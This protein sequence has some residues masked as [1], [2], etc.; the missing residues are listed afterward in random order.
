MSNQRVQAIL[1]EWV[2]SKMLIEAQINSEIADQTRTALKGLHQAS[3]AHSDIRAAN[4]LVRDNK[5]YL[6]DLNA[7][8]TLPHVRIS[9]QKL[10]EIQESELQILKLDLP[11]SL[12]YW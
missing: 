9:A 10:K 6:V 7:S 5:V 3:T 4:V 11:C 8:L 2:D 12:R 1:F